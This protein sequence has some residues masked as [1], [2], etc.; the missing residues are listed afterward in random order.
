MP[1]G[2]GC[3]NTYYWGLK[4]RQDR[5][6]PGIPSRRLQRHIPTESSQCG[7]VRRTKL[8]IIKNL[9]IGLRA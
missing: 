1:S 9:R 8:D 6:V 3:S 5:T 4:Q 2:S 7:L